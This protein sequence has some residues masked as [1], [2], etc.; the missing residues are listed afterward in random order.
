M[1]EDLLRTWPVDPSRSIVVGDSPTD[2]AAAG[3]AGLRGALF[4]G[5]RL[6]AFLTRTAPDL[7]RPALMPANETSW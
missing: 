1:I 6:D 3:A 5:G 2:L 4:R 7:F